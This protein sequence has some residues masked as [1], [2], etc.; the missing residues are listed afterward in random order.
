LDG[1]AVYG[2]FEAMVAKYSAERD[3]KGYPWDR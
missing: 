2:A 3:E 1:D